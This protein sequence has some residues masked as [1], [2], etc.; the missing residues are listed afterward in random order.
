MSADGAGGTPGLETV[1]LATALQA[2]A[3]ELAPLPTECRRLDDALGCVLAQDVHSTVDLPMFTQSAVDGYA[4]RSADAARPLQLVGA[5]AA[6]AAAMQALQPGTSV[7]ILTGA[8]LPLGSDCV[9]RQEIVERDADSIRVLQPLAV[10]A[11][12]R[13]RGEELKRGDLIA[14]AGQ[15]V[16]SGLL[17][18]LAM[19]G[20]CGVGVRRRPRVVVLVTGDEVAAPGAALSPAQVFD[21]NGPLVRAWFVE[22][23]YPP[24]ELKYV[25][26]RPTAVADALRGALERADLVISTGGVSVGDRDYL[27]EIAPRLGVRKVFWKVA[28]KPGKPLWFGECNGVGFLGLPGNPGAVL[29]GLAVHV[30]TALGVLEGRTSA[31]PP[32]CFGRLQT[33]T[34]ADVRCDR[35]VRMSQLHSPDGQMRLVALPRQESH[36]L[37]NLASANALAWLPSR[38]TDYAESEL[39]RWIPL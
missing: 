11:D 17:A 13:W 3:Q 16:N 9:A 6:G 4:L 35:L 23:G 28:Q 15:R 8:G 34:R 30:A 19:A 33:A 27:P 7:R 10:G 22:R 2:Y 31:A 26:D 14:C 1:S 20:V 38:D 18:A 32:W 37:S 21:A 24:P 39:V 36:M 25:A 5:V 12:T 29:V